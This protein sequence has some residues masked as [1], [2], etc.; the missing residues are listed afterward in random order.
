MKL[1]TVELGVSLVSGGMS[2]R[3]NTEMTSVCN[4]RGLLRSKRDGAEYL[5]ME[6]MEEGR[7]LGLTEGEALLR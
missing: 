1:L 3:S 6:R 4:W 7:L 5:G 2:N